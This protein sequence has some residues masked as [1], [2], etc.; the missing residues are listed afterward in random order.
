M[1]A[2]CWV[3]LGGGVQGSRGTQRWGLAALAARVCKPV[4]DSALLAP[5]GEPKVKGGDRAEDYGLMQWS[6]KLNGGESQS[7]YGEYDRFK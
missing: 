1:S 5:H 2:K 7:E 4:A 6:V 3:Q